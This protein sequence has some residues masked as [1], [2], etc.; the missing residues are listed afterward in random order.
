MPGRKSD[1]LKEPVFFHSGPYA[2]DEE[3]VDGH[4]VGA[5]ND[6]TPGLLDSKSCYR[7]VIGSLPLN[8]DTGNRKESAVIGKE[9]APVGRKSDGP[10]RL[11]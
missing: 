4:A 8:L 9:S 6:M 5:I 11:I 1:T 7:N 10:Y 2:L 3:L